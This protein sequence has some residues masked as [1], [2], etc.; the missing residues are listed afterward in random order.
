MQKKLQEIRIAESQKVGNARI[1]QKASVPQ[2]PIA[3]RKSLLLVSGT[4]LGTLLGI[5]TAL[6]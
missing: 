6:A 1:I 4:L 3:S 2:E 5:A